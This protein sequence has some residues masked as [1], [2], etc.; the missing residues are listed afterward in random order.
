M[1]EWMEGSVDTFFDHDDI[2][3]C[4]ADGPFEFRSPSPSRAYITDLCEWNS[5][6]D[7]VGDKLQYSDVDQAEDNIQRM[8]E[9][10]RY[11]GRFNQEE[12]HI[13]RGV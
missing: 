9:A 3:T 7:R 10:T 11:L 8:P 6:E 5:G 13:Y 4:Y 1:P 12:L 2:H